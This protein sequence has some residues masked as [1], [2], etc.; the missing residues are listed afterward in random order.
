MVHL[1]DEL[2]KPQE[3]KTQKVLL[4][5]TMPTLSLVQTETKS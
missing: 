1:K 3:I 5:Y 2:K 4:L